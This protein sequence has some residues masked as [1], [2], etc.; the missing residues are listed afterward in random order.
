MCLH[1]LTELSVTRTHPALWLPT[2][3]A[4]LQCGAWWWG[5]Q[6][7]SA[8]AA[9]ATC[10][11]NKVQDARKR[12]GVNK[13]RVEIT[14]PITSDELDGLSVTHPPQKNVYS[15]STNRARS[16]PYSAPL[17]SPPPT[18]QDCCAFCWQPHTAAAAST[19]TCEPPSLRPY[20]IL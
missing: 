13:S 4:R 20:S 11:G 8:A 6:C 2:P 7:A 12:Q 10:T 19:P 15:R 18:Y 3:A 17:P 9:A 14:W 1:T 16:T 5:Q